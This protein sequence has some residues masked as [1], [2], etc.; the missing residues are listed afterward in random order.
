MKINLFVI[1]ALS[2][3]S[4]LSYAKEPAMPDGWRLPKNDE[5]ADSWRSSDADHFA[6]VN[7]DFDG[8]KHSDQAK[9]LVKNDGTQFGV[10][11]WLAKRP[12]AI[13]IY[14]EK[15]ITALHGMGIRLVK[16]TKVKTICGKGYDDCHSDEVK[17]LVISH[18]AIDYFKTESA[19]SYFYWDRSTK[20]FKR[21]WI[22]D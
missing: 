17:E 1:M 13:S 6:T 20:K 10:F 8:D 11:V 5:L 3:F 14:E 21:S 16:P 18:D 12:A 9:L 4:T 15:D 19:N 22:S 7:G 2:V